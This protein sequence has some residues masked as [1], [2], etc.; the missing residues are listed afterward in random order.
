[1]SESGAA[2]EVRPLLAGE[3][4]PLS[5]RADLVTAAVL[6]AFG[7]SVVALALRM[8]TFVEQS[9]AG[10]TAPG[11]VPGFHGTVIALLAPV[12]GLRA[13]QRGA[14]RGVGGAAGAAARGCAAAGLRRRARHRLRGAARLR[15]A[16]PLAPAVT[17]RD[18]PT[19]A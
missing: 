2:P 17:E 18:P 1:L 15:G 4:V 8:P 9:G 3:R 16:V 19:D 13:V 14:L 11:I 5:P 6:L 10:L 7:L 12:L